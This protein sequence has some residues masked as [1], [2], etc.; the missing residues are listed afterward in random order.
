MP[1]TLIFTVLRASA[2]PSKAGAISVTAFAAGTTMV[3]G[4]GAPV[5]TLKVTGDD[6]ALLNEPAFEIAV[7]VWLPSLSAVIASHVKK[8]VAFAVVEQ[9]AAPSTVTLTVLPASATPAKAGVESPV[10]LLAAGPVNTGAEGACSIATV[11]LTGA[12]AADALPAASRAAAEAACAPVL[13]AVAGVH[14]HPPCALALAV[15][16]TEPSMRTVT[17]EPGS[18][19]PESTGLAPVVAPEEGTKIE[20][21]NGAV[22]SMRK[23]FTFEPGEALSAASFEV[24]CAKWTLSESGVI[25][26]QLKVPPVATAVQTTTPS[27]RTETVLPSSAVPVNVGNTTLVELPAAG[28]VNTGALGAAVST[29]NVRAGAEGVALPP[30]SVAVAMALCAPSLKGIIGEQTKAPLESAWAVQTSEPSTAIVT[31]EA[32]SAVPVNLGV[33]SEVLL[34]C[35]G[36]SMVGTAGA[37]LSTKK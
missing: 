25:A 30:E 6:A 31:V 23:S 10:T 9:A 33:V 27:T 22:V 21:V 18:D 32:A 13:R 20:G 26:L 34:P 2:L 7:A 14:A 36:V 12:E 16:A 8:P 24:A 35:A 17:V 28:F 15:H 5:S 29:V 3:G 19:K 37:R 1:S 11:K 4:F